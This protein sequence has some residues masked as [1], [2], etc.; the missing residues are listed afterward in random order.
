MQRQQRNKVLKCIFSAIWTHPKNEGSNYSIWR[1]TKL[2]KIQE[3]EVVPFL[4]CFCNTNTSKVKLAQNYKTLK[5]HLCFLFFNLYNLMLSPIC[6]TSKQKIIH[7]QYKYVHTEN[8][9][10]SFV[11]L[12][13]FF[14]VF[15]L[16]LMAFLLPP[17]SYISLR[18]VDETPHNW[19]P[20]CSYINKETT[21]NVFLKSFLRSNHFSPTLTRDAIKYF[22]LLNVERNSASSQSHIWFKIPGRLK[23]DQRFLRAS[24]LKDLLCAVVHCF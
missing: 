11:F 4:T 22:A 20:N 23:K 16:I 5:N 21:G 19:T 13:L 18:Y 9:F 8:S 12:L 1:C 17:L 3:T 15:F 7:P 2:Q 24:S 14:V 6:L 10:L